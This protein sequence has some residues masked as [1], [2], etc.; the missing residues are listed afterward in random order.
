MEYEVIGIIQS[1]IM[2]LTTWAN[3]VRNVSFCHAVKGAVSIIAFHHPSIRHYA[4]E[5][6]FILTI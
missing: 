4:L 6:S 5:K 1:G 3:L 2:K